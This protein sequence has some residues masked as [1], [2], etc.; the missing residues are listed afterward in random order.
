LPAPISSKN[1]KSEL[2]LSLGIGTAQAANATRDTTSA[3]ANKSNDTPFL[4][5]LPFFQ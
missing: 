4:I 2:V 5:D 3:M 1:Q